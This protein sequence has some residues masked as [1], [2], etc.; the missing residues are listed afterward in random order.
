MIL[1]LDNYDSFVYNLARYATELGFDC[2]TVRNDRI[3]LKTIQR[4]QPSHIIISPGPCTPSDAGIAMSVIQAFGGHIPLLG[5]CLGHQAIAQ[6]LGGRVVRAIKPLHGRASTI[7]HHNNGLFTG[8][9]NPLTVGR[10]HSLVVERDS[11]PDCLSID[12]T[13][14]EGDIM[15]IRHK[16]QPTYG[17]QFHPESILTDTGHAI[18]QRFLSIKAPALPAQHDSARLVGHVTN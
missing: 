2:D 14:D 15:A 8:L 6:A 13:S 11:L 10:Y 7:Q 17:L 5:I 16:A 12:A 1:L 4:M 9:P 18:I 3:D